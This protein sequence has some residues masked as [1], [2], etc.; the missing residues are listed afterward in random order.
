MSATFVAA[1]DARAIEAGGRRAE[2]LEA[3]E[4][5][6]RAEEF[7]LNVTQVELPSLPFDYFK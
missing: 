1:V 2:A 5:R 4:D 7:M 6:A 3:W